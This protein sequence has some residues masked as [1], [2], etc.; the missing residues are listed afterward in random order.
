M[1]LSFPLPSSD[2]G[3]DNL[4][5]EFILHNLHLSQV[6]LGFPL[7]KF[8]FGDVREILV[9]QQLILFCVELLLD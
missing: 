2:L 7:W 4:E 6:Y 9:L 3:A 8:S 5:N 1:D